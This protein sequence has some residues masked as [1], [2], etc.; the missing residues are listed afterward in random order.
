MN[1]QKP[2]KSSKGGARPGA[3]RKRY[4]EYPTVRVTAAVTAETKSRMSKAAKDKGVT[5]SKLMA[6]VLES[7]FNA[8]A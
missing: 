8:G 2:R 5:L 3:G 7:I 4:S 6:S 1:T